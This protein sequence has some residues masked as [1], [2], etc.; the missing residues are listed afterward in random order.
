MNYELPNI[1]PPT[2]HANSHRIFLD[3]I[4]L[5]FIAL[6]M[7]VSLVI[8]YSAAG[9]DKALDQALRF[10]I[11]FLVLFI[12]LLIPKS[13]VRFFSPSFYL[14]TVLLLIGVHFFGISI[15]GSQRWLNLGVGQ[16]QPSEIAKISIPMMLAY[17]YHDKP[18]PPNWKDIA[19]TLLIILIPVGLIFKQPDL[20]TSL[21]VAL[22]GLI[23]LFLAGISWRLIVAAV[24]LV[25]IAGP[26]MWYKGGLEDYQKE[27]VLTFLNPESDPTGA[28]YNII[29]SKIAIGSG[30][31]HGKGFMN[32]AQSAEFL[33]ERTTDFI[34]AVFSEEFGWVGV[35][36]LF[37]LF[38]L[39][40]IRGLW[41]SVKMTDNY[42]R[43]LSGALVFIF[44][45]YFFINIGM[46]S[47]VMPVVGLPLPLISYGGTSIMTLMLGF[48]LMMNLYGN[49]KRERK[50]GYEHE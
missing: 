33:P 39:V 37:L 18:L 43:L 10:G 31:M 24:L 7:S 25:G 44:F 49:R 42:S 11:G 35:C 50:G 14:L 5:T 29:Q 40:L 19:M 13:W 1:T 48:G 38:F 16:L 30:G 28:G 20:G 2:P 27:R 6:L 3:V 17:Y 36:A 12:A 8:L 45:I 41:L 32:G 4:L 47:G 15:N 21:L 46:V 34:F 22:S 9:I 26:T 23:V